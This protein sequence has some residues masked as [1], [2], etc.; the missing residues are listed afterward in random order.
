MVLND[1]GRVVQFTWDDLINHIGS[2]ELGDFVIMPDY[3]HGIITICDTVTASTR[4]GLPEI[5]RQLKTFSAKRINTLRLTP[6]MP[7][8]QRNY[9]EHCIRNSDG[10]ERIKGYIQNNPSTW[11]G[12]GDD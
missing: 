8:W 2:I 1:Y 10:Y 12:F 4:H 3:V 5:V 7:V 11:W 6:G 9:D